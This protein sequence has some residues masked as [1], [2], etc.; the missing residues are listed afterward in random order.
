MTD[1]AELALRVDAL[2]V[3][4][5]NAELDRLSGTSKRVDRD[6]AAFSAN[7]SRSLE[8]VKTGV[9]A[10]VAGFAGLSLS[11][12][13]K[14][15]IELNQ[16]YKELGIAMEVV[17]RNVGIQSQQLNTTTAAL[18]KMGISMIEARQTV[19]RLAASHIDLANAEKLAD[20]ARNA[21]IVGQINT[22]E[23][24]DRIVHG[25]RSA[26]VEVLKTIGIT[27]QFDQAYK[28]L[29]AQLGKTTNELTQQEKQQARVNVVL[30]EAPAL[31][32]LYEAAMNNAGKQFRS[33]ERLAEN[34]K[35]KIGELFDETTKLAVRSYT[36]LLKELDSTFTDLTDSGELQTWGDQLAY[37]FAF[38][39]DAARVAVSPVIIL[40]RTVDAAIE[41]AKALASG[42]FAKSRQIGADFDEFL[43]GELKVI[44]GSTALRDELR[45]QRVER[46]LLTSAVGRGATAVQ[47]ETEEIIESVKVGKQSRD[48]RKEFI[49][50]LAKQAVEAG[51]SR[52]EIQR[53]EAALLGVSD[54]AEPYLRII[55]NQAR[56]EEDL[57]VSRQKQADDLRKI[58]SI[59]QSVRT[60]QEIYND[61]VKELDDLL[62]KGLGINA[63]NRALEKAR[64]E[65]TK[66]ETKTREF[67]D[68]NEQIWI[69][70]V[71]NVQTSL[72]NG[73]FNVFDDGLKGMV[74]GVK[75]A[76]GQ[77][78]AEFAS[79][80]ILQSTGI[81]GLLGLGSTA[82]FASGG[83]SAGGGLSA[84]NLASL[85]SGALNLVQGGFGLTGAIGGGL[86]S[87]G[88]AIGSNSLFQFG[89]GV[90][91]DLLGAGIG[92]AGS[93]GAGL[94]ALA[95]P[96]AIAGIADI[97]LRQLFGDKKL[98]GTAGDI[99]SYVPV[100]GTLINGLFGRGA[101]KFQNEAL[102]GNVSANGFEGVLNQ[103]FRE[104][105]GVFRSNRTSNF[106]TDTDTGNLLNQF[107]RLS[108]SGNIPGALRDSATDPAVKRA[109]EVG[110]FLDEAF[111]SIG[112]TLKITADK[113]GLSSEALNNFSAELDLVSEKGQ[114]LSEAQIAEQIA[115]ISDEMIATLIP[116]L[117]ELSKKGE[118][119]T[120]TLN[121]LNTQ[122]S[123]LES[124]AMLFGNTAEQAA[125]KV[126]ALGIDGQTAFIDSIG[127]VDVA[128]AEISE[129]YNNVF[130]DAQK[131][132][133]TKNQILGVLRP[134]GIDF[135]PTLDQLYDAVAS[136]NPQLIQAALKIDGLVVEFN[137]LSEATGQAV[138][139]VA[140]LTAINNERVALE[141]RLLQLQGDT[142]ALRQRELDALDP[143]NR[144]LLERIFALEDENETARQLAETTARISSERVGLETRLL[145]LQGDTA[146]LRKRE[147][148]A[149]DPANRVLLERIF[150]I[151]DERQK[152]EDLIKSRNDLS[153][154]LSAAMSDFDR[155]V[156]AERSNIENSFRSMMAEID[157][158]IQ[159]TSGS[160]SGLQS[161]IS[162]LQSGVEQIQ[163][164]NITDAQT[165]IRAELNSARSGNVIDLDKIRS[166][167][168]T[169]SSRDDSGFST[170]EAF[171]RARGQDAGL[172]LDLSSIATSELS[173][174]E[175]SMELLEDQKKILEQQLENE[176]TSLSKISDN[177]K[178]QVDAI[179]GVDTTINALLGGKSPL[180]VSIQAMSQSVVSLARASKQDIPGFA[181]GGVHSGGLRIVGERGPELEFT[182][183]S[184]IMSNN[185]LSRV[186]SNP[187]AATK[188]DIE[189]LIV[190]AAEIADATRK[191]TDLLMR[192]TRDGESLV[193][194]AA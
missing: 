7:S 109:L 63:Y 180:I 122:F 4:A 113:L 99:L 41:R 118:T 73:L 9:A 129:F 50:A 194:S 100:V 161:V 80:K 182:G 145:Q 175:R 140:D 126:R 31:V 34:L 144:A 90:G 124:A 149:L 79:I 193:T 170:R 15:S 117:G 68:T 169:V 104:K 93:L 181:S 60:K 21:A 165:A 158:S 83:A 102:V 5:A 55:E 52:I 106:I 164:I 123:V 115:R 46:D 167:I 49:N 1:I 85:G 59:T 91:G 130:T 94:G 153:R 166:A 22:S 53:M 111:S 75:R 47:K 12:S 42:D 54:A 103:A 114:T 88:G 13:I 29:A 178:M 35:I 84:L 64:D 127:G 24:L 125:E 191:T 97:G 14:E 66:T 32:G 190:V 134:L 186:I 62:T 20:L 30:G 87:L 183:P 25:I 173:A 141:T 137:Q 101:P 72:A 177:T 146:E 82:A 142:S 110:K 37:T 86:Q 43:K 107:G 77:M 188:Q 44:T 45:K 40:L 28:Q 96:A 152:N 74:N 78:L 69:Q 192:V 16:R 184:R 148:D 119:S 159:T 131:L 58:E 3:K 98:G 133:V 65:L 23:A 138:D 189:K 8:F 187:N 36:N 17:G 150:A 185:D 33:T 81:A 121:R 135:I 10:L 139:A 168:A 160:V 171:E 11:R 26:E 132:E 48:E 71:R 67:W 108:E 162:A 174:A 92:T 156:G 154:S 163:G 147:L 136:G 112:D 116:N 27:V 157:A 56:A 51:K 179:L 18:E 176:L 38:L 128:A 172:L 120:D 89:A 95:G 2:E 151:E 105:G 6:V 39:G 76:V 70:G 19:T 61:T 143:A 57:R 155:L